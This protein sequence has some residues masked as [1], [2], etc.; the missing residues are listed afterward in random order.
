MGQTERRGR[1]LQICGALTGTVMVALA[2]VLAAGG[3]SGV[4]L[5]PASMPD[6]GGDAPARRS[7]MLVSVPV[8]V[9]AAQPSHRSPSHR[10]LPRREVTA[11]PAP[12]DA[13]PTERVPSRARRS[14]VP[15]ARPTS[16][17][18]SPGRSGPVTEAGRTSVPAAQPPTGVTTPRPG[19]RTRTPAPAKP[20]K[21]RGDMR[22]R[23]YR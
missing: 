6:L 19:R 15:S 3:L 11:T 21:D 10:S 7:G 14:G 5:T 2:G 20:T 17:A 16:V 1:I 12:S 8:N 13:G 4:S 23:G 18:P 9:P 22:L